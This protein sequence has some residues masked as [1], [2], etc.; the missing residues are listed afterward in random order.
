M[1]NVLESPTTKIDSIVGAIGCQT[2]KSGNV[3]NKSF[4]LKIK[5][6]NE[7]SSKKLKLSTVKNNEK[8]RVRTKGNNNSNVNN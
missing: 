5:L 2:V 6:K 8:I 7:S 1:N 4:N 3:G